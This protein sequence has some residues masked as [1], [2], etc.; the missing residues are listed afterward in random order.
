MAGN[1]IFDPI[2]INNV[3]FKNRI[4][5]SSVG[6]RHSNYDGTVT[7]VWKNFE[8]RFVEG[9][10]AG[11][12]STTF[13]VNACRHSPLQYPGLYSRAQV[14]RL[15]RYMNE[16]T[17]SGC[18]YIVQIGDTGYA[19]QMSL[20]PEPGDGLSASWGF[21][22][23]Y[24]YR[25][26]RKAMSET[27]VKDIIKDFVNAA[28]RVRETG[29]SGLEITA[30]KGYLIHQFL[31]PGF[32]R[33]KDEWGGTAERRFHLLE[34]IVKG[35]RKEVGSD[36]LLGIRLAAEDYNYLPWQNFL[37]RLPWTWP[38][39]HHFKGN[40]LEETLQYGK[41]LKELEVDYLHIVSGFGFPNPKGIPGDFPYD[42]AR[43]YFNSVR[44]L[45]LKAALRSM[46]LNFVP[47]VIAKPLLNSGW[48][49]EEGVNLHFA[50]KFKHCVGLPVI[51]NGGFQRRNVIEG[52]LAAQSC[53]LISMAR[54]LLANPSLVK[55]FNNGEQEPDNPC[56][57]CNRCLG[58][59]A[60]YPLGC[61]NEARF[62]S[63]QAM[64]DQIMQWNRPDPLPSSS[65]TQTSADCD[66]VIGSIREAAI[67]R[68]TVL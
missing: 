45:S 66:G 2:T 31:N 18:V 41:K 24:G 54:A 4:V 67:T 25:N 10:V 9:G 65:P 7:D 23:L 63:R 44:H 11:V 14:D 13:S 33:R 29:A 64:I 58:R 3:T 61:Y 26:T 43:I 60:T 30:A 12:I 48:K 50:R 46:L 62:G 37:F 21:D 51:V 42:E 57:W 49:P 19:T 68:V 5:R 22:I 28:G 59:T 8:K 52:A 32:N 20:F 15:K 39:K 40:T 6:G 27:Q 38:L 35:V 47:N 36:F 55:E 1:A 53:D 17:A 56:V 34:E 16:L